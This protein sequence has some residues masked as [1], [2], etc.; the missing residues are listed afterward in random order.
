MF[1]PGA[2]C[3]ALKVARSC[4]KFE[5]NDLR[6]LARFL[7][8]ESKGKSPEWDLIAIGDEDEIKR[9]LKYNRQDVKALEPVYLKLRP[10]MKNHP[11]V[12]AHHNL[13]VNVC[14]TC[15]S[16]ELQH[17]GFTYSR[18]GKKQRIQC[19]E[20]GAWCTGSKTVGKTAGVK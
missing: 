8:L 7:K 16:P 10:W 6:Y 2:Q 13:P 9:C 17:R 4:F 19:V 15:A 3:R 20:C 18:T 14:P 11:N 1:L 5:A 12:N